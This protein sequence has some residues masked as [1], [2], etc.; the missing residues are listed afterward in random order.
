MKLYLSPCSSCQNR[1]PIGVTA[2]TRQELRNRY[3][4]YVRVECP[5]CHHV[6][7]FSVGD[8][9]AVKDSNATVGGG[10]IGGVVGL[11]GGP[12]GALIGL[13]LGTAIGNTN[14]SDDQ[15]RVN[16]FNNSI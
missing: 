13:G 14:E 3:G 1:I 9:Y 11:L 10:L 8:V 7:T 4:F 5:T 2:P 16:R 15:R 12:I 6:N